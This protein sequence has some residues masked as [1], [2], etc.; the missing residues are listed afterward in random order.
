MFQEKEFFSLV[1]KKYLK[2]FCNKTINLFNYILILN[3]KL[4]KNYSIM[5]TYYN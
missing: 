1:Q 5:K 2:H 4:V 3:R